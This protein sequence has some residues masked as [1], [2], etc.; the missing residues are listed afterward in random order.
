[1][2]DLKVQKHMRYFSLW[3]MALLL[4]VHFAS[5]SDRVDRVVT[6]VVGVVVAILAFDFPTTSTI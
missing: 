1:L 3:G 4:G 6:V 2:V 5:D